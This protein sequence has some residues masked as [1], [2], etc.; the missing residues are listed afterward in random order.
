M[1]YVLAFAIFYVFYAVIWVV[2][3][4]LYN[5]VMG[6]FDFGALTHFALKSAALIAVVSA[7]VLLPFGGWLA[8]AVWWFGV[9][10][11][12]G[13]EFWEAKVLVLMIWVLSVLV[14]IGL[15]AAFISAR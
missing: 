11:L 9:V 10:L 4:V 14:R 1:L 2:S 15:F 13:M 12:F 8:L 3:L 6:G 7:V 5:M